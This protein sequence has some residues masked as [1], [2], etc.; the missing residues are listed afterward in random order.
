M[1]AASGLIAVSP[2]DGL[3][4]PDYAV[5]QT[6][7]D[8]DPYYFTTL[9]R[10]KLLQAVFR[11]ESTGLGTGSSGFLRLYSEN[12][13]SLWFPYPPYQEQ[14]TIVAYIKQETT[15]LDTMRDAVD[16]S[17]GLLKERRAALIAAAVTGSID[18]RREVA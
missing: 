10:T 14:L 4:S 11:S 18:V 3:V 9:F 8:V 7:Q 17:I 6:A 5:F 2:Q 13:L 15:K 16:K 1:R 12:F